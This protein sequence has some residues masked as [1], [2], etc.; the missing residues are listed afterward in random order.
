M[1][2]P[3]RKRIRK[4]CGGTSRKGTAQAPSRVAG[5][6]RV[7]SVRQLSPE[8]RTGQITVT[9]WDLQGVWVLLCV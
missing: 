1:G 6:A 3:F 9:S 4:R 8:A 2:I 7:R 5:V